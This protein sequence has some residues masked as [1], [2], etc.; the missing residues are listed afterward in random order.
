LEEVDD[1]AR[2]SKRRKLSFNLHP[3]ASQSLSSFSSPPLAPVPD[4]KHTLAKLIRVSYAFRTIK[5]LNLNS[6]TYVHAP[7]NTL[8]LL[9]VLGD[10]IPNKIYQPPH[11]SRLCDIPERPQEY[12][13]LLYHL[14]GGQGICGL[15]DWDDF[16]GLQETVFRASEFD[17]AEVGGWEYASGPP[18]VKEVH[19]WIASQDD[20]LHENV[21]LSKSR[22]QV[23]W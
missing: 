22:S 23:S 21:Q 13:G 17:P 6:Y 1:H 14:Q 18:S 20:K 12:A 15:E 16:A 7:P 5:V 2:P 3:D 9:G 10:N 4:S 11:Y 19:Y 8:E